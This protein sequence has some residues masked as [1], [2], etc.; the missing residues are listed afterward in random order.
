[1]NPQIY[2]VTGPWSGRLGISGR[3]RGGDWLEDE[4]QGWRNAGV[5][6][7]ASLLTG[8]E[9]AELELTEEGRLAGMHGIR[10]I[11]F[12]VLDRGVPK[13]LP[14]TIALLS[15]VRKALATGQTVAI[16]CRQGI[17]RSA[18]IAAG[19]L[20]NSGIEPAA[21]LEMVRSA[22]GLPVPET[23]EQRAWIEG[24][25]ADHLALTRG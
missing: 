13:S 2:W 9:E 22:R 20:I 16:H 10:F 18:L 7:V 4:V 6:V 5:D 1:M 23:A 17:G 3:P 14:A 19:T 8:E 12:P 24:V 15:D 21:A 25:L 11:S